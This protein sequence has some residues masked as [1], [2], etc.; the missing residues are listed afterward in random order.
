MGR[1][2]AA[3]IVICVAVALAACSGPAVPGRV[4]PEPAPEAVSTTAPP[5]AADGAAAEPAPLRGWTYPESDVPRVGDHAPLP[6][7]WW[8]PG[9]IVSDENFFDADAMT[10]EEIQRFLDEQVPY[11]ATWHAPT[12]RDVDSGWPYRCLGDRSWEVPYLDEVGDDGSRYCDPIEPVERASSAEVIALVA[13]ACEISPRTLLVTLEK[14]QGLVTDRWPWEIQF[15]A[16]MG[17][18]CYDSAPCLDAYGG[19]VKQVY[20]AART[21]QMYVQRPERFNYQPYRANEILYAPGCEAG[22]VMI[23]NAA[24]AALYDYTPYQPNPQV[25]AGST[26]ADCSAFGNYNFWRLWFY[27]FGDPLAAPGEGRAFP[28]RPRPAD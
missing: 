13:R 17:Y 28:L 21:Y 15:Q 9:R 24:T 12:G 18:A 11:C 20:H 8:N 6:A 10:A 25:L 23:E 1:A 26:S 5:E 22:T 19:F 27:W 4:G 14:E 7:E 3:G 2:L 16:A